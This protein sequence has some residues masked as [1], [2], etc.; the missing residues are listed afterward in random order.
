MKSILSKT[1]NL[2]LIISIVFSVALFQNTNAKANTFSYL[3][4]D[5]DLDGSITVSD[6]T[7][8]QMHLASYYEISNI[9][10]Y[11]GDVDGNAGISIGDVTT[12]QRF[13][14][15]FQLDY[16]ENKDMAK[17]NDEIVFISG[18][19]ELYYK[20][21]VYGV[22]FD[23]DSTDTSCTRIEDAKGFNTNYVV[24]N[25]FQ[26]SQ[27]NDFDT[28]YPWCEIRRCNLIV[29]DD[30]TKTVTYEGEENF[31]LDGSN[32]DVMVEI[33]KFYS[34]REQ[35]NGKEIW[36]VTGEDKIGFNI[37]P[38][39]ID[40]N[41]NVQDHIYV[42]AYEFTNNTTSKRHSVSGSP[43]INS[44][45]M[46]N[47]RNYAQADN[48][49]CMDYATLRALQFLFTIEFADRNTDK[50]MQGYSETTFFQYSNDPIISISEDRF[51][52]VIG[53]TYPRIKMLR[54]GQH[55]SITKNTTAKQSN[56]TV[57][58]IVIN[59]DS[60]AT[61][62][63]DKP[64]ISSLV[65][66]SSNDFFIAGQPQGTGLCDTLNYHT[67]RIGEENSLSTFRYRYIE[68]I[69]GNSWTLLEGLRVKGLE[70]YYTYDTS[71]YADENVDNWTNSNITAPNQPQL[72][73]DGKN[74][75]WISEMGYNS[76]NP[77]VVLPSAASDTGRADKFYSSA[78][79]TNYDIDKN[80]NILNKDAE[81]ICTYGGGYDHDTLCGLFTMRFWFELNY[82]IAPLHSSRVVYR[83]N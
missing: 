3:L 42:G 67:G 36:A 73:D 14:A 83:G 72:G 58:N 62:S 45:W 10:A 55:V 2:I 65:D 66:L 44:L 15:K 78:I 20:S 47:Y 52:V 23:I 5:A 81:Y 46:R 80:G 40:D 31:A 30:G 33:P 38:A 50:Y 9:S 29:N 68:N 16:P 25:E 82:E 71:K 48:L 77:L 54:V 53:Y 24:A 12:I 79:Y 75:A 51:S 8:L 13:L 39:F 64:V 41:G 59:D 27:D 60:T 32:G 37:E 1:L 26:N 11:L 63:F 34:A 7:Y 76:N 57:T 43:V 4:G 28:A 49:T 18:K 61:V 19:P 69:W 22:S 74:R 70:Y 21:K 56:L 6:V 17:I 35:K